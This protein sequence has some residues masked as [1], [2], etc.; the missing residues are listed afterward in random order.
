MAQGMDCS[1]FC[2]SAAVVSPKFSEND[3]TVRQPRNDW[4]LRP[5]INDPSDRCEV[6]GTPPGLGG[7]F[8][9]ANRALSR[10]VGRWAVPSVV[11]SESVPCKAGASGTEI[12]LGRVSERL[13]RRNGAIAAR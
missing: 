6:A 2:E 4:K 1:R 9:R 12:L 5:E 13:G 10:A 3:I 8:Y 7:P 11:M